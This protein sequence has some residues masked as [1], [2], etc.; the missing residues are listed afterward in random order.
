MEMEY[1][2]KIEIVCHLNLVESFN[3]NKSLI[4][5]YVI[6]KKLESYTE[7]TEESKKKISYIVTLGGDGTILYA[8]K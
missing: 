3:L 4:K 1:M 7:L 2:T 8:A 6:T 5:E